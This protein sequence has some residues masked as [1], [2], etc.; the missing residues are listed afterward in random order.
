MI[1]WDAIF[2]VDPSLD[3]ASW[4]CVAMLIRIRNQCQCINLTQVVE[5]LTRICSDTRRVH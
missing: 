3:I 1:L 4:V 5:W 2:A